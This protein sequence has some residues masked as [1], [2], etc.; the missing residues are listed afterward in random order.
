MIQKIAFACP[1]TFANGPKRIR[2][3][4]LV[5]GVESVPVPLIT[6]VHVEP[7]FS[8]VGLAGEKVVALTSEVAF[9]GSLVF[10]LAKNAIANSLP[11]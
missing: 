5:L 6:P 10:A 8:A 3:W 9:V 2:A 7:G 1:G 11:T 4:P